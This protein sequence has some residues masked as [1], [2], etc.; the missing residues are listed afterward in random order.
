VDTRGQ[1]AFFRQSC[2]L[3]ALGW[4]PTA[5]LFQ[6]LFFDRPLRRLGLLLALV[7]HY[8]FNFD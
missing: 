7:I 6:L 3:A 1:P 5:L 8:P 2:A 4:L